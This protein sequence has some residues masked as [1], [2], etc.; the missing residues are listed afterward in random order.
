MSTL[1][2]RV[3]STITSFDPSQ[4]NQPQRALDAVDQPGKPAKRHRLRKHHDSNPNLLD[5]GPNKRN[6]TFR[7]TQH[8]P[9]HGTL[10]EF[11][12]RLARKASTFSLR[13][14]HRQG[15]REQ[16]ELVK[17]EERFRESVLVGSEKGSPTSK[18]QEQPDSAPRE[19]RLPG[20]EKACRP[21]GDGP[22]EQPYTRESSVTTVAPCD[23]A[24]TL[25]VKEHPSLFKADSHSTHDISTASHNLL[26]KTQSTYIT[27]Y[28]A[29]GKIAVKKMASDQ[30]P[31]PVPYTRLKE[32]TENA[33]E[34][35]LSG[36]TSYSHSETE[37]WNTMI[38][39]SI[40]GALVEET[41]VKPAPGSS[42]TSQPQYKYV[43]NSTIIQ[44]AAP[45]PASTGDDT[46]KTSGRRGMHAASGAYW[47]NEKDGMWSFK[48][49]GADSKGLDVVVGIIWVWVG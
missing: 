9:E 37:G 22:D 40:L 31:P 24:S 23:P 43:V 30:A 10:A 48:Y 12:R 32:I 14:R 11:R 46:K 21:A 19:T 45:S 4:N 18:S 17:E 2:R 42:T 39:N 20:E 8:P 16:D 49:P 36:A 25:S 29:G 5:L 35:A 28:V 33:C 1:L 41:T 44:H 47:N 3:K 34:A 15:E 7:Q 13:T 38:I 27:K 26:R 6:F